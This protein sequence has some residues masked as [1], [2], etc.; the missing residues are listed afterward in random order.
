MDITPI[1]SKV[2]KVNVF[3]YCIA[4]NCE[5]SPSL[6]IFNLQ[7]TYLLISFLLNDYVLNDYVKTKTEYTNVCILMHLSECI[8]SV[9]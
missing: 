7:K 9:L 4:K 5:I 3:V 8:S 2:L 6:L 1:S